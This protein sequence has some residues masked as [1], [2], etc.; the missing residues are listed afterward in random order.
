MATFTAGAAHR[1]YFGAHSARAFAASGAVA[2]GGPLQWPG[3]RRDVDLAAHLV[4]IPSCGPATT[5]A[6][7][8]IFPD[9]PQL[10]LASV[11]VGGAGP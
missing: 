11:T 7:R 5:A 8:A 4:E 3:L 10:S 6:V 1:T 9:F 2:L